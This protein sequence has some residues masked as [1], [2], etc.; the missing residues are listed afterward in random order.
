MIRTDHGGTAY[1]K[2]KII[3][4]LILTIAL[5]VSDTSMVLAT[6]R[7]TY[8][9]DRMDEFTNGTKCSNVSVVVV[10][11]DETDIFGDAD[12]LYLIGSMT[13]AFTGLAVQKLIIAG[14]LSEEDVISELIPGF[15]AYHNGEQCDITIKQ[16]LVQTS[17]YTNNETDYPAATKDMT[18]MEWVDSI[19]GREL[20]SKPG[21][22]YAYSNVNYNLLGALI[23]QTT[24][25][26]Y[27]DYM[28]NEILIPLGLTNTY[29]QLPDDATGLICGSRPGYRHGFKYE[30]PV[31][32]GKIPAGYFYSNATDM[33]RWIR[34]W[35]GTADIP[36]EYKALVVAVKGALSEPGDY[37][38]GWE[39]F[40][41]GTT[42][43]SG[44]TPDY[45]SRIVFSDKKRT[46]VCVLANMNVAASTDSLCNGI[47]AACTG[48]DAGG[49]DTD[50][51][52]VFDIIFTALTAIGIMFVI[53]TLFVK[54]RKVLIVTGCFSAVLLI[55]I[56]TVMPP[57]F[58]ARLRDIMFIWA[59][60]SFTGGIFALAASILA[61]AIKLWMMRKNE[62]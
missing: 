51:W 52:T 35:I 17:G 13:K 5:Y 2:K 53:L 42:G 39:L 37:Y 18:L 24:G 1:E 20:S 36:K 11:G 32:P 44:G 62:N 45:S 22:K 55:L 3:L 9:S 56:C 6:D 23:E 50:V 31:H 30:I 26:S 34:I 15:T 60:Y 19:S 43:H 57:V 29:V 25:K 8:V 54:K 38:S 28:E 10:C 4:L 12:G 41:N 21:T 40:E 61:A 7:E 33:A 14:Q 46:G 49:I 47:F 48:E 59:P 58:G 16:L 27:K